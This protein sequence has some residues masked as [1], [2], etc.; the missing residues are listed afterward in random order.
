MRVGQIHPGLISTLCTPLKW[1][2][3]QIANVRVPALLQVQPRGKEREQS[4]AMG[5]KRERSRSECP[6]ILEVR[7]LGK[8]RREVYTLRRGE[9]ALEVQRHGLIQAAS[10]VRR[11][12]ARPKGRG[13]G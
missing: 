4:P 9:A 10:G 3:T 7:Q 8:R 12:L 1:Q 13:V 6:A 2:D 11:Q 5:P